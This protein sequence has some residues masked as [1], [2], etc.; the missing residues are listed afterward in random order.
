[1]VKLLLYDLFGYYKID[2]IFWLKED[3]YLK[4]LF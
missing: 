3:K 1:M 4:L 2:T